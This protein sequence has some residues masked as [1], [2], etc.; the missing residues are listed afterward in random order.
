MVDV[1]EDFVLFEVGMKRVA[2][3]VLKDFGKYR[4]ER[5]RSVVLRCMSVSLF[6]DRRDVSVLPVF[7]QRS[8]VQR[9]LEKSCNSRGQRLSTCLE[10]EIRYLVWAAG[11]MWLDLREELFYS[12]WIYLDA[13]GGGFYSFVYRGKVF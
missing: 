11:F 10:D 5:H 13:A 6:E 8:R 1:G 2:Y 3:D 9:L 4:R 12:C 7:R